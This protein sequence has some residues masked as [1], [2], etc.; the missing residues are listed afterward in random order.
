[1]SAASPSLRRWRSLGIG[2]VAVLLL[3]VL[4]YGPSQS[5]RQDHGSSYNR[6]PSGYS[7]WYDYLETQEIPRQRWQKSLQQLPE[8]TTSPSTLVRVYPHANS[9]TAD[10]VNTTVES[11]ELR[12]W[13]NAGNRLVVLGVRAPV[14]TAPFE[15]EIA[16]D[17]G[18]V[19]IA[20]RRRAEKY[21]GLALLSDAEGAIVWRQAVGN[22]EILFATTSDLAANA[23][24]DSEGNFALLA[25][26]TSPDNHTVYL[27]ETLHGH[28]DREPAPDGETTTERR[29]GPLDYLA[30][31][32]LLPIALQLA[33]LVAIAIWAA[34]RR[35]GP[36]RPLP[37]PPSENSLAYIRALAGVLRKA[38]S[39][40][41]V[42]ATLDRQERAQL[43]RALG[44]GPGPVPPETIATA[45]AQRTG[46]SPQPLL[47]LLQTPLPERPT[48]EYLWGWLERWQAC[49]IDPD[50][51]GPA[52]SPSP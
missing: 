28:R 52:R 20:T 27:D 7:A 47:A 17:Y 38:D 49:R 9:I 42:I 19:E 51:P 21:G 16:S 25:A 14:S 23:Y 8:V 11:F 18:L 12:D 15:R 32:P 26:I 33:L 39:N 41:F 50:R 40:G 34:N 10:R 3:T 36:L 48:T 45:W 31:T 5:W 1:M 4:F 29:D 43:Q 35:F 24:Q 30:R 2:I 37:V 44:L 22:G 13:L 46:R 6:G